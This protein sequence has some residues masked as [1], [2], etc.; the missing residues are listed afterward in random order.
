MPKATRSSTTRRRAPAVES[1]TSPTKAAA[2]PPNDA[3]VRMLWSGSE[4]DEAWKPRDPTNKAMCAINGAAE[5]LSGLAEIC[6]DPA[7]AEMAMGLF[8][9]ILTRWRACYSCCG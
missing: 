1:I 5:R 3:L 2:A 8:W 6:W 7:F 4:T 9:P